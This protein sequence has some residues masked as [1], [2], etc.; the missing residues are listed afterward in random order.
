MGEMRHK[1]TS[2][3]A[4]YEKVKG[5]RVEEDVGICG[6][7]NKMI[8]DWALQHAAPQTLQRYEA[9]GELLQIGEDIKSK[10][11]VTWTDDTLNE[12]RK[13]NEST[14]VN[15]RSVESNYYYQPFG[16]H[17]CKL[18][19]PAHAMEWMYTDGLRFNLSVA[20]LNKT[21]NITC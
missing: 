11:D 16:V 7:I 6:S 2:R 8:I 14:H 20:N 5:G 13:C 10:T 17:Y 4:C 3:Q 21:V 1:M 9:Y 18:I 19:S 12:V 15:Y